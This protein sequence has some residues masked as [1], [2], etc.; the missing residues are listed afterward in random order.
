MGGEQ[1]LMVEWHCSALWKDWLQ[2]A[3]MCR[4]MTHE[5]EPAALLD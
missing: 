4:I 2:W 3:D 5:T 1:G